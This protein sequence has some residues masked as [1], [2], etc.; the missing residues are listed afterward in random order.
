M[1]ISTRVARPHGSEL[2][3]DAILDSGNL[4]QVN[5]GAEDLAGAAEEWGLVLWADACQP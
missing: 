2:V 3:A 4:S 1:R 5:I